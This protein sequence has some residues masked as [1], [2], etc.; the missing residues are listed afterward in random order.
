MTAA[1][2]TRVNDLHLD[3]LHGK[4]DFEA[5]FPNEELPRVIIEGQFSNVRDE[6]WPPIITFQEVQNIRERQCEMFC[7]VRYAQIEPN[8]RPEMLYSEIIN[9]TD[10][11]VTSM[12]FCLNLQITVEEDVVFEII[13][14]NGV[15]KDEYPHYVACIT[16]LG[17]LQQVSYQL[18]V[19]IYPQ[20]S[21]RLEITHLVISEMKCTMK[22]QHAAELNYKNRNHRH[23]VV[24][25]LRDTSE[26]FLMRLVQA[27][28][29][30]AIV[31][32]KDLLVSN[33]R[34]EYGCPRYINMGPSRY[35]A[36]KVTDNNSVKVDSKDNCEQGSKS[37]TTNEGSRETTSI[38]AKQ[39]TSTSINATLDSAA[40]EYH[41]DYN[42]LQG[43]TDALNNINVGDILTRQR[44]SKSFQP[45]QVKA[46]EGPRWM[47][48]PFNDD[49]DNEQSQTDSDVESH[50]SMPDLLSY[51][52]RSNTAIMPNEELIIPYEDNFWE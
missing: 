38:S 2:E 18:P 5:R 28:N 1:Q 4:Y 42:V 7:M 11:W 21:I 33:I 16:K 27:L 41:I 43:I 34:C 14:D 3:R 8:L 31:Q 25:I 37:M 49:I 35:V 12:S 20:P 26:T 46:L 50:D 23:G 45:R 52:T 10:A 15:N 40:H 13:E 6:H 39:S 17:T 36:K 24:Q 47:Q 30:E 9:M 29:Q 19:I 51:T 48:I 22:S 32:H 44:H